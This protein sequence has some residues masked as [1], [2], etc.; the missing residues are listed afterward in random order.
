[1]TLGVAPFIFPNG[2]FLLPADR[3]HGDGGINAEYHQQQ[4]DN[5]QQHECTPHQVYSAHD[6]LLGVTEIVNIQWK[7]SR[8]IAT[9]YFPLSL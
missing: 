9:A 1:M 5:G 6:G 7:C 4:A 3:I 8:Y 2:Y